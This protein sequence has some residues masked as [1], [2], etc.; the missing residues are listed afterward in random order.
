MR[1]K[2]NGRK[3]V[4]SLLSVFMI[5]GMIP[6][7]GGVFA[8]ESGTATATD[9]QV[10]E[11]TAEEENSE[12]EEVV[13]VEEVTT[14]TTEESTEELE[15]SEPEEEKDAAE[16]T[17]EEL[18]E[19]CETATVNGTSITV[20]ADAGVFPAGSTLEVA[21]IS[22]DEASAKG[23]EGAID[24]KRDSEKNVVDSMTFDIT[25]YD[26]DGN[27]IE[28]DNSKG[29]V[30]ITFNN[31]K[32]SNSNLSTDIY[33]IVD[34]GGTYLAKEM[35]EVSEFGNIATVKTDGFSYYT[36]EFTYNTFKY[37]LYR[38]SRVSIID[39][40]K[41]LGL[42]GTLENAKVVGNNGINCINLY[43]NSDH[44]ENS[45]IE[46]YYDDGSSSDVLLLTVDGTEFEIQLIGI[47]ETEIE[48]DHSTKLNKQDDENDSIRYNCGSNGFDVFGKSGGNY[49]QTTYGGNGYT[50][51]IQV[52][53]GSI[54]GL[55]DNNN[56]SFEFGTTYNVGDIS[57][58]IIPELEDKAVLI[59][60]IIKNNGVKSTAVKLGSCADTKIGSTDNA[61]K[62]PIAISGNVITMTN[63]DDD[64]LK[65]A[66]LPG[67]G[68]FSTMWIG[69][70]RKAKGGTFINSQTKSLTDEDSGLAWSW[71]FEIGAGE[72]VIKKVKL[73]AGNL[74]FN[75][76]K[77]DANGG[78][79][80]MSDDTVVSTVEALLSE[81]KFEKTGYKFLGWADSP[82]ATEPTIN[83]C[84]TIVVDSDVTLYAVWEK[85]K[86]QKITASDMTITLKDG[87]KT[88]DAKSS[89]DGNLVFA[90]DTDQDIITVKDN[91]VTPLKPGKA[92]V[93][94]NASET[95]DY[96]SA[97]TSITVTVIDGTGAVEFEAWSEDDDGF[98]IDKSNE[99]MIDTFITS[100]EKKKGENGYNVYLWMDKTNVDN[101]ITD[102]EKAKIKEAAGD[103]FV[104]GRCY[105]ILLYKYIE[106]LTDED[107][108]DFIA[109]EETPK[110]I[111]MSFTLPEKLTNV[112]D[113]VT[114]EYKVVRVHNE[115]VEVIPSTYDAKT[116]TISFASD[117][118]SYFAIT[119]KDSA[120][121]ADASVSKAVTSA[122]TGDAVPVLPIVLVMITALF[123][124]GVIVARRRLSKQDI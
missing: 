48:I 66:L 114:R 55:F 65:F 34:A 124:I 69:H 85:K 80:T 60:Y 58:S 16:E 105:D 95:D 107:D 67:N 84:G 8:E 59:S 92:K 40:M 82:D 71:D 63:P 123:G 42:S 112:P 98:A 120:S 2:I 81:N 53:N 97:E 46:N 25:I 33:H 35:T 52:N 100:D 54:V 68:A 75:T 1:K 79:G 113:G 30:K 89:G 15:Q 41:A 57:V 117:R 70:Y 61:D 49:V 5:V 64:A 36:L 21:P 31:S 43:F 24:T 6:V 50:T 121:A 90:V 56:N 19:F 18:V 14:E 101:S 62:A 115:K 20:K 76:I 29:E 77:Y 7:N 22:K 102:E 26:A 108:Y 4:A 122:K 44:P 23:V 111:G 47:K 11:E 12:K 104:I 106:S 91:V 94:I 86:E 99:E 9:A 118:F 119:Y 74:T 10:V 17:E 109:I 39:L 45:Y 116:K 72:T 78:S 96:L 87:D 32:I 27:E 38:Y 51:L 73:L 103:G 83:D 37:Y 93:Y 3:I 13:N 28:P 110:P 88:I